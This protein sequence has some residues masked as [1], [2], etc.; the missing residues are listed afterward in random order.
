R[1]R[2]SSQTTVKG[3]VPLTLGYLAIGAATACVLAVSGVS[4]RAAADSL[5]LLP[6]RVF[7]QNRNWYFLPKFSP[8]WCL[9]AL[10]GFGTAIVLL[11]DWRTDRVADS[12]R[13]P[14]VKLVFSMLFVACIPLQIDL[15]PAAGAFAWLVLLPGRQPGTDQQV[16]P[17]VVLCSLAV[18]QSLY[19]YPIYGSQ[20]PFIQTLLMIVVIVC[21]GD[22]LE[23]MTQAGVGPRW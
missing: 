8:V 20:A 21:A 23:W 18:M 22:S 9:W 11:R 15:F 7:A 13:L 5:V 6:M 12:R 16:F 4:F 10:L 1:V 2:P 14:I 17:R 3:F 19:A